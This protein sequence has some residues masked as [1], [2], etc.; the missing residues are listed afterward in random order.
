M[1]DDL[2]LSSA[3][4]GADDDP[5]ADGGLRAREG[6]FVGVDIDGGNPGLL[7]GGVL[8]NPGAAVGLGFEAAASAMTLRKSILN[9]SCTVGY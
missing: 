4:H 6:D 2:A 9:V 7:A 3:R 1:N 8:P 5:A